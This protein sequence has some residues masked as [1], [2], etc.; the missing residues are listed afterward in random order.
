VVCR[1]SAS[2]PAPRPTDRPAG[3]RRHRAAVVA[4]RLTTRQRPP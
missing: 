2:L 3:R 1:P 4:G